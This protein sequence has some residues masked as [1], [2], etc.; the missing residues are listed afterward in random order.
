MQKISIQTVVVHSGNCSLLQSAKRRALPIHAS[1][2]PHLHPLLLEYIVHCCTCSIHKHDSYI[3][4]LFNCHYF[5]PT[6]ATPCVVLAVVEQ[7]KLVS[8]QL[9]CVVYYRVTFNYYSFHPILF[10]KV[11]ALWICTCK[12]PINLLSFNIH[13][14]QVL[15]YIYFFLFCTLSSSKVSQKLN[16]IIICRVKSYQTSSK[17]MSRQCE[18]L[19]G[20]RPQE[21]RSNVC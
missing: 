11:K 16:R 17:G 14:W 4:K 20:S 19:S 15:F 6:A 21:H 7:G 18:T 3:Y 8:C 10:S 13:M 5:I 2:L 1:H 12:L 9:C